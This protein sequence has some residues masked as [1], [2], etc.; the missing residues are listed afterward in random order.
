M[1]FILALS[2]LAVSPCLFAQKKMLDAEAIWKIQRIGEPALSPDGKTVAFVV[3]KFDLE[4]NSS[5]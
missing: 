1:R 5:T 3:R 4:K 2:L